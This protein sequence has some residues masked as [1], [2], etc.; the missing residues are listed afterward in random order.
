MTEAFPT[1]ALDGPSLRKI[2]AEEEMAAAGTA[3]AA[4]AATSTAA[5][6]KPAKGSKR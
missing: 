1:I 3:A 6:S 2:R 5:P 4:T